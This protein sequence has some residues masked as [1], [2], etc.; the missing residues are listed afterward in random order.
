MKNLTTKENVKNLKTLISCQLDFKAM[1]DMTDLELARTSGT[2]Q[3]TNNSLAIP[4]KAICEQEMSVGEFVI[5]VFTD[6]FYPGE[7]LQI[8]EDNVTID[9]LK[10]CSSNRIRLG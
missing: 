2:L 7:I 5:G 6:G 10:S 9:S 3:D 4:H 1:A 8:Q